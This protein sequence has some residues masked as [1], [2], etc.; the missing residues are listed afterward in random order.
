VG[1][2]PQVDAPFSKRLSRRG[3]ADRQCPLLRQGKLLA[4]DWRGGWRL[5][6]GQWRN[7]RS[8]SWPT[9]RPGGRQ[10]LAPGCCKALAERKGLEGW[11]G[12]T[13]ANVQ[14]HTGAEAV[15]QVIDRYFGQFRCPSMAA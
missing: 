1:G 10:Q 13:M 6:P 7:S 9:C 14:E 12:P 11:M 4:D 15:R 8:S 3:L 2:S 5:A